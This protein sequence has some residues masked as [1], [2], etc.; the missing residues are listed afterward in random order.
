MQERIIGVLKLDAATYEEIEHDE[1]ALAQALKIVI[2]VAVL[3]AIG[4]AF[5]PDGKGFVGA[6]ASM[7]GSVIGWWIGAWVAYKVGTSLFKG[8]AEATHGEMLRVLGFAELPMALSVLA[9]IPG[10]GPLAGLVGGIW[11]LCTYF[12]A[13]RQGLDISNF[14]TVITILAMMFVYAFVIFSLA[15][16]IAIPMAMLGLVG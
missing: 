16:V 10:V 5:T 7:I 13:L 11:S 9:P 15:F 8:D 12:V 4:Q 14:Q 6:L 3:S 1:G 2:A